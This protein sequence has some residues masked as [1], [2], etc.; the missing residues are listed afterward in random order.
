MGDTH[1]YVHDAFPLSYVWGKEKGCSL[2]LQL[3]HLGRAIYILQQT[4]PD[5]FETGLISSLAL[6]SV[7]SPAAPAASA[8]SLPWLTLGLAPKRSSAGA[9]SANGKGKGKVEDAE[10][11]IYSP[12]VRLMYTPPT[13][14]PA[15]FPQTL[16]I[17]GLHLY[18]ASSIFVRHTLN[19]LNTD[20]RVELRRIRVFGSRDSNGTSRFAFWNLV[21]FG[22]D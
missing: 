4:L 6:P 2:I 10:E 19:A 16:S 5:F 3:R 12:R 9:D 14:L 11:S 22:L 7:S 20:L 17:E 1:R 21:E 13:P 8:W 15:P 18:I